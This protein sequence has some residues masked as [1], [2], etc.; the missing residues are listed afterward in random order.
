M[1]PSITTLNAHCRYDGYLNEAR[2]AVRD[3]VMLFVIILNV[4]AP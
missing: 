1:T 2:Y 3:A 4:V